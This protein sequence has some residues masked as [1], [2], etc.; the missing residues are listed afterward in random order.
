[1]RDSLTFA[2]ARWRIVLGW[3]ALSRLV[4]LG[5]FLV[6]HV[7]GPRGHLGGQFYRSP[8]GLLGAWDGVW[9]QRIA[10]H[11]YILI[12]GRQ[13]DT[14]FFPLYPILLR[15]LH[16]FELPYTAAGAIISNTA[17]AVGLVAFYELSRKFVPEDV[18]MRST[19]FAAIAPLAFIYSMSYPESILLALVTTALLAAFSDRW[20]LAA[21][22]GA[23]AGLTRPEAV[24]LAIPIATHAWTQRGRLYGQRRG[25]ALAAIAAAPVAVATFP[26]YLGWALH[27]THA[28]QQSQAT[29]GRHF[30][31]LGPL[32][33]VTR[34]PASVNIHPGLIRDVVLI[35]AYGLLLALAARA[36]IDRPWVAAGA[37][38]IV[39]PLFTGSI[40][41]EGR[42]GLLALPVYWSLA[43]LT[44]NARAYRIAKISCL[45][46]LV[47][48]VASLPFIWP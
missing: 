18:A 10:A 16:A 22:L 45:A 23:L 32:W 11:G 12:P 40:E 38:V 4:T 34:L 1:L 29:W 13:S 44:R 37:A 46:G 36:G 24:V 27:D 33:A 35:A 19:V 6:L 2:F 7:M 48:G 3:W 41:S 8:L 31:V 9:Y 17:F 42:F 25:V 47:A 14:A 15:G 30:Q 39:L 21:V 43:I 20:G 28:W 26:M 5:T